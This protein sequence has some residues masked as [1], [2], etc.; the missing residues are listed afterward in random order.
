MYGIYYNTPINFKQLI[1]KKDVEKTNL[2]QSIAKYINILVTS[3]FGECKFNDMLGCNIWEMDFDLLSDTNS[4]RDKFKNDIKETIM[5]N[6][7]RLNLLEVEVSIGVSQIPSYRNSI[8]FKKKV[9][10]KINGLIKKTNRPF[11]FYGYFF[12]GPLSQI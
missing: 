11:N 10:M 5:M 8:R 9:M 2:D 4:L 3:S 12:I 7:S 1:E 6:E